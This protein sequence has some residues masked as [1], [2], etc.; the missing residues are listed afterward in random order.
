VTSRSGRVEVSAEPRADIE[1]EGARRAELER[2]EGGEH[3]LVSGTNEHIV[4]RCPIAT[5]IVIG[6]LSGRVELTGRLGAVRITTSSGQ[7]KV[8]EAASVDVRTRS[9]T[10]RVSRC[11]GAV[12]AQS[13]SARVDIE[14]AAQL[15]AETASGAITVGSIDDATVRSTSGRVELG[16]NGSGSIAARTVSGRVEI[17]V[18][19]GV[20]PEMALHA[21]SGRIDSIE[22]GHDGTVAVD[23]VSGRIRVRTR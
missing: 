13:T 3:L 19:A 14:E 17:S 20:H 10:L 12:R 23:T 15:D 11:E 8:A 1:V 16:F 7:V 22:P 4:V 2:D 21:V 18:P 6:T 9:G 5:D